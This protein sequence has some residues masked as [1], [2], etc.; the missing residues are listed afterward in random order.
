MSDIR[1]NSSRS[2]EQIDQG[3]KQT[4]QNFEKSKAKVFE[5]ILQNLQRVNTMIQLV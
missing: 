4:P 2:Q 3:R 1:M 5:F